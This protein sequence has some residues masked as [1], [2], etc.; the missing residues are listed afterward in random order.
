METRP[1]D[2]SAGGGKT[3]EEIVQDKARELLVKLPINYI[4]AEVREQVFFLLKIMIYRLKNWSDPDNLTI[5]V[6][7]SLLTYSS[8]K[9]SKECKEL[10]QS[11][12]KPS[13]TL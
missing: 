7:T 1:K 5:K 6:L 8:T 10:S 11:L 4:D 12:E 13:V 3:R 2:S 9:N